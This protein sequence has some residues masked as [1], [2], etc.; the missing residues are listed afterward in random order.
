M[1][2]VAELI[3]GTISKFSEK[4]SNSHNLSDSRFVDSKVNSSR[5][6]SSPKDSN[7]MTANQFTSIPPS[8][9]A[10]DQG[11]H[12]Q[13]VPLADRLVADQ[14]KNTSDA[15][16]RENEMIGSRGPASGASENIENIW[17]SC[18]SLI[19]QELDSQIYSAWIRPLSLLEVNEDRS[20]SQ[21]KKF[22]VV[23]A[24]ANKFALDHVQRHYSEHLASA[25]AGVLQ[26]DSLGISF[27][28]EV[29]K[30]KPTL[31]PK[32]V[33]FDVTRRSE[34]SSG[35]SSPV[36]AGSPL[37]GQRSFS[38]GAHRENNS[39]RNIP[40]ETNLN[41][42]Y[43]FSNFVVGSCNQFAHAACLRV[44]EMPGSNY[45]PLFIYGGVGLGKTH[46]ANAIGNSTRRQNK[47][48]L[49]VSSEA[50]VSELIAALR[51]NRMQQFKEK[52]RTLDLLII[53]D[54]QFI[55]GK[56]RTQ[57]EFFHTFNDL[58]N[59][60]K[61]IIITSDTV[62]QELAGVE[63]RLRTRFAC[64]LAV[65]L[66]A[67]D[68][69]T[70]VAILTK[71]AEAAG[72]HI[73]IDVARYI[74]DAINTNVRELEGAFNRLQA[75]CSLGS[76]S[77][78]AGHPSEIT[79]E[80]AQE[81][82]KDFKPRRQI[83]VTTELI[84]RMV[85]ERYNVSITDLLGKRRTHNVALARQVAMFLCRKLTT[86]SYPEIGAY[87][88]GRDHSTVIHSYRTIEERVSRDKELCSVLE[89]IQKTICG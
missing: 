36:S 63:E 30:A 37:T 17:S 21:L 8:I 19:R 47:K 69:E 38:E 86:Y 34:I 75:F 51:S 59:R 77:P 64:G 84:Q 67:P 18:L 44:S 62:P 26:A 27:R 14:V 12:D 53:D 76:Y 15:F 60:R 50:F 39:Q 66:Q 9:N 88:G 41:P 11:A 43:N 55:M 54:I 6:E 68:L 87:F 24:A 65:D 4:K 52:F 81:V 28:V 46:L 71:K 16:Q 58:Y 49:L 56:E 22:S 2:L 32:T 13:T 10:L 29:K 78:R 35:T 31:S 83:E 74:A 40:D 48:A 5:V 70:R 61:Q 57:E 89:E 80:L 1:D 85:S 23:I 7:G 45:N 79:L 3:P 72:V 42:K 82:V 73:S 33:G 20:Q 25:L